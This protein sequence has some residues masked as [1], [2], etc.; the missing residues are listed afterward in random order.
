MTTIKVNILYH[1][2]DYP[3]FHILKIIAIVILVFIIILA[4]ALAVKIYLRKRR[5]L[6]NFEA[7]QFNHA[8]FEM[9][10]HRKSTSS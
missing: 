5:N 2:I 1:H 9:E 4:G 6:V 7:S 8:E 3:I 10:S